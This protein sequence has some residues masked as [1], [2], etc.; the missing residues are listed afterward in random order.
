[1]KIFITN[2]WKSEILGLRNFELIPSVC[3]NFY[4]CNTFESIRFSWLGFMIGVYIK[5]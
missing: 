1:M 3:I 5:F 2:D 4:E